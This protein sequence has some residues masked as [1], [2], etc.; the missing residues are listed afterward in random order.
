[1]II[2]ALVVLAK[3]PMK[4]AVA[5]SLLIITVKSLLGFLGDLGQAASFNWA[6]LLS[7]TGLAG[8]GIYIGNYF[9]KKISGQVLKPAFGWFVLVMGSYI[10]IQQLA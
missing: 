2:P 6:L 7:I 3:I 5:T 9:S 10:L 1:M 8:A 4:Q